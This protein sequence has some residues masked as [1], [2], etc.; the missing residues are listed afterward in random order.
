MKMIAK[1]FENS[2]VRGFMMS[3]GIDTK[4]LL[5]QLTGELDAS[6]KLKREVAMKR[7]ESAA[8]D[9]TNTTLVQ[10]LGLNDPED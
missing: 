6:Q 10:I 9:P 2:W 7:Y 1:F 4:Q 5:K 8:K 3:M